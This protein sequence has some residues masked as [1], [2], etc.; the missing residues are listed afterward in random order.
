MMDKRGSKDSVVS[1]LLT[2][3]GEACSDD[4]DDSGFTLVEVLIAGM[5]GAVIITMLATMFNT[6][7]AVDE[8]TRGSYEGTSEYKRFSSDF[9]Q[10]VRNARAIDAPRITDSGRELH[11]EDQFGQC[12]AFVGIDSKGALLM[13]RGEKAKTFR[14]QLEGPLNRGYVINSWYADRNDDR[15][16][17]TFEGVRRLDKWF[18]EVEANN[19]QSGIKISFSDGTTPQIDLTIVPRVEL[20]SD[21]DCW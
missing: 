4:S 11:I 17:E 14:E 19:P 21:S 1:A 13:V 12:R 6:Y 3:A 7:V 5:L 10:Y 8:S 15:M 20:R 16:I 18:D 9:S 2:R